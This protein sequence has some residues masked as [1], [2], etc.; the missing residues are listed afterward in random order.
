MIIDHNGDLTLYE[1]CPSNDECMSASTLYDSG[2]ING[3]SLNNETD[4]SST[5]SSL[6]ESGSGSCERLNDESLSVKQVS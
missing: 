5:V 2:S 6:Y 1:S 3:E 4:D